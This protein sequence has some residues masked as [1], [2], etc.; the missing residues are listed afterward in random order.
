MTSLEEIME[1]IST[2]NKI[3]WEINYNVI[4][5]IPNDEQKILIQNRNLPVGLVFKN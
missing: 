3:L 1:D 5:N 2:K 4:A